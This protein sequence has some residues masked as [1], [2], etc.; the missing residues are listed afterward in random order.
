MLVP[1]RYKSSLRTIVFW[2]ARW[3]P[4]HKLNLTGHDSILCFGTLD[5]LKGQRSGLFFTHCFATKQ[6]TW[7]RRFTYIYVSATSEDFAVFFFFFKSWMSQR[8]AEKRMGAGGQLG[9][10][11][12]EMSS[13]C[14]W[15]LGLA[16]AWPDLIMIMLYGGISSCSLRWS[17][18]YL[19]GFFFYFLLPPTRLPDILIFQK[20]LQVLKERG[21]CFFFPSLR[22]L[23]GCLPPLWK[24]ME[25]LP[26]SLSTACHC[27]P[28][29]PM[30]YCHWLLPVGQSWHHSHYPW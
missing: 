25:L 12:I 11:T 16:A 7:C 30:D 28:H 3:L 13:S 10:T 26:S 24:V 20:H 17:E 21:S 23:F 4:V 18:H 1:V 5:C 14:G 19:G 9:I 27:Q 2:Q 22:H 6:F 15:P 8:F 29:F